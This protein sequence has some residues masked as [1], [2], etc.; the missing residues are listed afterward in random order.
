[1]NSQ[2]EES[3]VMYEKCPLC[4]HLC[5]LLSAVARIKVRERRLGEG[6]GVI[7]FLTTY[8][9]Q[10]THAE[11]PSDRLFHTGS[12]YKP[13]YPGAETVLQHIPL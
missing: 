12:I 5:F 9:P 7:I 6:V 1:M 2:E 4:E 3:V 13:S 8:L 11:S 10:A